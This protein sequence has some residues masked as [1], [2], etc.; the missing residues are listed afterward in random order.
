MWNVYLHTK[1]EFEGRY[2]VHFLSRNINIFLLKQFLEKTSRKF[3]SAT[4]EGSPSL[5]SFKC[6]LSEKKYLRN[7]LAAYT[8]VETSSIMILSLW[9]RLMRR[10]FGKN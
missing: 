10:I 9:K 4:G 6:L 8:I 5:H 7:I 2:L 3:I 1:F